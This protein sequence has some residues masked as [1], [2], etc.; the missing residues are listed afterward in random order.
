[1]LSQVQ[2]VSSLNMFVQRMIF[3]AE[4]GSAQ[5][6]KF[7]PH[8]FV[9]EISMQIDVSSKGLTNRDCVAVK[10]SGMSKPPSESNF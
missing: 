3:G 10:K 4:R 6:T 5:T 2:E 1:M 8:T 7:W 9:F